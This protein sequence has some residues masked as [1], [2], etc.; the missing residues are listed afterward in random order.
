VLIID[1][2]PVIRL[3]IK[4]MMSKIDN[5]IKCHE[6]ENGKKG[7]SGLEPLQNSHDNIIVLLDINMPIMNGWEFLDYLER[8]NSLNINLFNLFIVSSSTDEK[9]KVKAQQYSTVNK[10]FHKPLS[11]PDVIEILNPN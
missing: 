4:M 10:F 2:D 3:I 5:S 1:D 11:P 8:N 7:L 6:F 9:D